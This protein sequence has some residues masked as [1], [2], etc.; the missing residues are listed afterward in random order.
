M[1]KVGGWV[2]FSRDAR[3]GANVM[4]RRSKLKKG[5]EF[6]SGVGRASREANLHLRTIK[7]RYF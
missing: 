4:Q 1:A 5:N 6:F 2:L 7:R 3:A